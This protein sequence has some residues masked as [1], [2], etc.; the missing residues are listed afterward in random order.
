MV[1]RECMA[2]DNGVIAGL[3]RAARKFAIWAWINAGIG[4]LGGFLTFAA[5]D[6]AEPGGSYVAFTGAVVF[7]PVLAVINAVRYFRARSS[8]STHKAAAGATG[9]G[10]ARASAAGPQPPLLVFNPP[11]GWPRPAGGWRPAPEW[12][13]DPSW[14]ERPQGW[15]LLVDPKF[16][17]APVDLSGN[18]HVGP[19]AGVTKGQLNELSDRAADAIAW[20]ICTVAGQRKENPL[21]TL[22]K[23]GEHVRTAVGKARERIYTQLVADANAWV[24]ESQG[25]IHQWE[26]ALQHA[27]MIMEE[28]E[29][30]DMRALKRISA[31][32]AAAVAP[33][34]Q[35]APAPAAPDVPGA[36]P[37]REHSS[38]VTRKNNVAGIAALVVLGVLG[39]AV[40]ASGVASQSRPATYGS[41]TPGGL[42]PAAVAEL[43][44][45]ADWYPAGDFYTKWVPNGQYTCSEGTA[46]V[47]LWIQTPLYDGCSKTNVVVDMLRNGT[48]VGTYHGNVTNLAM[49]VERKVHINAFPGVDPDEVSLNRVTCLE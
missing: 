30:F 27:R 9:S 10:H 11:P 26:A 13:P 15:K 36:A 41:G 47:E 4:I 21:T 2:G 20:Q 23:A 40:I 29:S 19:P 25:S 37:L 1:E 22:G 33:P 42:D 14:P 49:G 35:E 39:V 17:M 34:Q 6:A 3:E 32:I 12:R 38:P 16:L 44:R 48:V 46:C 8:I 7:G 31:V 24:Q 18:L 43:D 28:R 5:Y 45:Q